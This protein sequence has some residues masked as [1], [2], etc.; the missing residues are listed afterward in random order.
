[1]GGGETPQSAPSQAQ[2]TKPPVPPKTQEETKPPVTKFKSWSTTTGK[3]GDYVWARMGIEKTWMYDRWTRKPLINKA[4]YHATQHKSS[5]EFFAAT[6]TKIYDVWGRVDIKFS[7][8]KT[9]TYMFAPWL[10]TQVRTPL[11]IQPP[12]PVEKPEPG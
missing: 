2:E 4:G 6:I 7:S 8:G 1:M 11:G 12:S 10:D 9:Q 5:L 3:V